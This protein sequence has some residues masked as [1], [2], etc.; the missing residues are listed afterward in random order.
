LV[1]KKNSI[2]SP[3]NWWQIAEDGDHN[4]DPKSLV[5]DCWNVPCKES[6]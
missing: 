2:F 6:F 5:C 3:E 1:F 4:I